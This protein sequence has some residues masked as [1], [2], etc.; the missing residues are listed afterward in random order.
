MVR[1]LKNEEK[2][3]R[4]T[5]QWGVHVFIAE[6]SELFAVEKKFII[7]C[8]LPFLKKKKKLFLWRILAIVCGGFEIAI[9][10]MQTNPR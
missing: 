6:P 7:Y 8:F 2:E 9:V 4:T 5:F 10:V 1:R 3:G